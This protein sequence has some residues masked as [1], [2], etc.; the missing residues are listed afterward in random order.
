M[1]NLIRD[2]IKYGS[3]PSMNS[4]R[5]KLFGLF[6][7]MC[8]R[9]VRAYQSTIPS[10]LDGQ[11]KSKWEKSLCTG[12][13][14]VKGFRFNN[15][16]LKHVFFSNWGT[17]HTNNWILEFLDIVERFL[18][19]GQN[20]MTPITYRSIFGVFALGRHHLTWQYCLSLVSH[21]LP[22][23]VQRVTSRIGDSRWFLI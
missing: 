4:T 1:Q 9:Y 20:C 12:C 6:G 23:L 19:D 17:H 18:T 13:V 22:Q 7:W 15:G 16:S 21:L 14:P 3:V 2:T 5:N 8:K 10:W 11:D